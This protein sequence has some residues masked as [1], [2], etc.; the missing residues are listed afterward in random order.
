MKHHANTLE[1]TRAT[2]YVTNKCVKHL[3][4]NTELENKANPENIPL[5][6]ETK[7]KP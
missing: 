7:P 6:Q 1:K 5:L 2:K 3:P 4:R